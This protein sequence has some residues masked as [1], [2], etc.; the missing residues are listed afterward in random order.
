MREGP[1]QGVG[2]GCTS[3]CSTSR[4]HLIL[5]SPP[6]AL[7]RPGC[8]AMSPFTTL[9]A[10]TPA[11]EPTGPPHCLQG[12]GPSPRL[13]VRSRQRSLPDSSPALPFTVT[14]ITFH[15]DPHRPALAARPVF[16]CCVRI[17]LFLFFFFAHSTS[18]SFTLPPAGLPSCP[19]FKADLVFKIQLGRHLRGVGARAWRS[20]A[21]AFGCDCS[22]HTH[23]L[24]PPFRSWRRRHRKDGYCH[25]RGIHTRLSWPPFVSLGCL[26]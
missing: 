24:Q 8:Q 18:I 26:C 11:H 1:E 12:Q 25:T 17:H 23:H 10:S 6:S 2:S 22:L 4:Q 3:K 15:C 19:L 16:S 9:S 7:P 20:A 14:R 5:A 21:D 13:G